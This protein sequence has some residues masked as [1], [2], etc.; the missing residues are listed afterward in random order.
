MGSV[1]S[2]CNHAHT[3]AT[4]PNLQEADPGAQRRRPLARVRAGDTGDKAGVGHSHHCLAVWGGACLLDPPPEARWLS[5]WPFRPA[6][7][8][9]ELESVLVGES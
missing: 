4:P 1:P 7:L 8:S 5:A 2:G 6:I 9:P 3:H